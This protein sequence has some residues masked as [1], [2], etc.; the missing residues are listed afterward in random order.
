MIENNKK[1]SKNK[2]K[3]VNSFKIK[4]TDDKSPERKR[5]SHSSTFQ[6][7]KQ[8]NEKKKHKKNKKSKYIK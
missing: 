6:K 3:L 1:M 7:I 4:E 8:K 5:I 2:R